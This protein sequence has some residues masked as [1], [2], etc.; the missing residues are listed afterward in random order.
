MQKIANLSE[1]ISNYDA[2]FS[3]VWG[4]VHNGIT[5]FETSVAALSE[6]K[7]MGK[8][9]ILITNAPSTS[10]HV[11]DHLKNSIGIDADFY[12]DIITSGD[13]AKLIIDGWHDKKCF[14]I[15]LRDIESQD[16][17]PDY[18]KLVD[19][20]LADYV[21][22]SFLARQDEV[23]LTDYMPLLEQMK[24]RNLPFVCS[25]PDHLVDV[26]GL[27]YYCAGAMADLYQNIGGEVIYTGKPH[28]VIYQHAQ[29][30]LAALK[31][32]VPP[33]KILVIGDSLGTDVPGANRLGSDMLFVADGIHAREFEKEQQENNIFSDAFMT[34]IEGRAKS[35]KV[36]V[37]YYISQLA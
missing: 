27:L 36:N 19:L 17:Q 20:N 26:G 2:V 29:A 16:V 28:G 3:D 13:V 35:L 30:K 4:V 12:D 15:G 1:I 32:D 21:L 23:E 24:Q 34:F 14:H 11:R 5:A 9:V 22:C 6:A 37:D 25:N 10:E 31:A 7:L 33:S 18:S 8:K